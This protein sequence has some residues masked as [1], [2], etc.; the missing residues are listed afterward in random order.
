M[1][2][3]CEVKDDETQCHVN[4]RYIWQ[5]MV[6]PV[7]VFLLIAFALNYAYSQPDTSRLLPWPFTS[8][9]LTFTLVLA[10]IILVPSFAWIWLRYH[11][12]VYI[13]KKDELVIRKGVIRKRSNAIPYDKIRNVQ[14][15]QSILDRAFGLCTVRIETAGTHTEFL[16]S[17]IPG[18]L[19]SKEFPELILKRM[20]VNQESETDIS[21]TMRQIL[22]QLKELNERSQRAENMGNKNSKQTV[23]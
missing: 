2:T 18:M 6:G 14:R 23:I 20:H 22:A 8:N 3:L 13:L 21:E 5:Q 11:S 9:I 17:T 10:I 15:L 4:P 19:N 7:L 12:F 1:A 16:D